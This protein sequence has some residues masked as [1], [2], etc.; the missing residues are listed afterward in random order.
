MSVEIKKTTNR[1]RKPKVKDE[2]TIK[3]E[4]AK[5]TKSE[6]V[7]TQPQVDMN[8]MFQMFQM[9]MTQMQQQVGTDPEPTKVEEFNKKRKTKFTKADLYDI[10][11]ERIVVTSIDENVV[12]TSPKS[13]IVYRWLAKGDSEILTIRELLNMD[14]YSKRFLRTPWLK[15]D[16]ER[17]IEALGLQNLYKAMD[18]VLDINNIINL[19]DS[20]IRGILER[21]PKDFK[22]MLRDEV[23]AKVRN[24]ELRD[25]AI[26]ETLSEVLR[27]DLKNL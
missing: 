8:Q 6:S 12:Y 5:E 11:N 18:K 1:G 23:A 24:K 15:V 3:E 9:F 26:I 22:D 21:L 17:V 13:G 10:E 16:D 14:N 25:L 19:T 2:A 27:V 7:N 4:V 20:E